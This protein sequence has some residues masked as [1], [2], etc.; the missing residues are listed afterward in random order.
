[1]R[2]V[3]L[4]AWIG[5]LCALALWAGFGLIVYE[6]GRERARLDSRRAD[7]ALAENREKTAAQLRALI[8]ETKS[9]RDAL[10]RLARTDVLEA[11]A[12]IEA[13][14]KVA[15]ARVSIGEAASTP[16]NNRGTKALREVVVVAR[17]EGTLD[18]LLKAAALFEALPFPSSVESYEIWATP[19]PKGP[20][21]D[22]WNMISR[23]RIIT[24]SDI[25]V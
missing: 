24:P 25:G 22:L 4:G 18:S 13:A 17:A 16:L 21:S 10:E 1:M 7:I 19:G 23:I 2:T 20:R 12:T 6:L 5:L 11:A 8:R 3:R 15:G 14:G 9:E